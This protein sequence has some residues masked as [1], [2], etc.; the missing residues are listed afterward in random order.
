MVWYI[1]L[2]IFLARLCDV[3]LGTM[4]MI[5]TIA[6]HRYIAACLGFVE[7]IIWVLAVGA[8]IQHLKSPV[9]LVAYGAGFA[10]GVLVGMWLEDKIALGYRMVR[11]ISPGHSESAGRLTER[12]R[13][14]GYRVTR[15]RGEGR[16]G[17]VEIAFL[18]I[19]RK[20]LRELRALL[21]EHAPDAFF[22]VER[23]DRVGGGGL[24]TSGRTRA[25]PR[26]QPTLV[27]K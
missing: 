27:D 11:V 4:R 13:E 19:P 24:T 25:S 9:A 17:P 14:N 3:P 8:A 23:V 22:T 6:G 18:V 15:V 2:L 5:L 10:A 7:V 1:P 26:A 16:D 12:L 21:A 20:K